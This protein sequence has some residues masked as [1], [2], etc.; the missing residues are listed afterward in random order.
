M[1]MKRAV[2]QFS[3]VALTVISASTLEAQRVDTNVGVK[4][5]ADTTGP[6]AVSVAQRV[7]SS[8]GGAVAGLIGGVLIASQ[9]PAHDCGCDDPG[10][11]EAIYGGLA[12]VTLGA[13]LGA[14]APGLHSVCSFGGRFG[15]SLL[16]G[17]L[18]T[19]AGMFAGISSGNIVLVPVGAAA[20]SLA[21]LGRCW[22]SH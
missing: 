6:T 4:A 12:G 18:G 9:F 2:A 5:R 16:G 15:R 7:F 3:L 8:A 1:L 17:G 10:L 21:A 11:A 14:S 20:G 19:V 22:K 13:A